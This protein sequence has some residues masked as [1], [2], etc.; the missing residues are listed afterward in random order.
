MTYSECRK[1]RGFLLGDY[2]GNAERR[3]VA[4]AAIEMEQNRFVSHG[5]NSLLKARRISTAKD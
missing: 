5:T 1:V 3:F 2:Q 4:R